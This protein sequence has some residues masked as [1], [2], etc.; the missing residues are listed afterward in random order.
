MLLIATALAADVDVGF[1]VMGHTQ[2]DGLELD[3]DRVHA[4]GVRIGVDLNPRLSTVLTWHH[5]RVVDELML[6]DTATLELRRG[7]DQ[8]DIGVR[9]DLYRLWRIEPYVLAQGSLL[10]SRTRL[11]DDTEDDL[12]VPIRGS[13]MDFGGLAVGG[14]DVVLVD[15]RVGLRAGVEFGYG[16]LTPTEHEELGDVHQKGFLA[17]GGLR[18]TF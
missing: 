14:L 18:M 13:A 15:R 1:D 11:D 2:H 17:R 16:W 10:W 5:R 3:K 8:W 7:S 4:P 9:A 12:G 6:P